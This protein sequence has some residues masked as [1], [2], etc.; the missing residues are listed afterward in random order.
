MRR[1][2]NA[3]QDGSLLGR[4]VEF[5]RRPVGNVDCNVAILC[6]FQFLNWKVG[7]TSKYGMKCGMNSKFKIILQKFRRIIELNPV[8]ILQSSKEYYQKYV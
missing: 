7:D 1:S 2:K 5:W 6:F 8:N 3:D 4:Q